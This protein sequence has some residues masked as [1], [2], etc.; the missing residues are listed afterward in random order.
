MTDCM[1][2]KGRVLG[3]HA[4]GHVA[5]ELTGQDACPG[6]R[7][8]RLTLVPKQ[9]RAELMLNTHTSV[10]VGEEVLVTM[11]ASA[12]LRAALYLHGLPLAGL[13]AGAAVAAAAGC[14]DLGCLGGAVTGCAGALL[15]LRRSQRRRYREAA[16]GLQVA[17]TA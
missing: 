6:C 4:D 7:C 8:G 1:V 14:G 17:P 12:V 11:P 9:H 5:V 16:K 2:A 10:R 13:L 3:V 15:L